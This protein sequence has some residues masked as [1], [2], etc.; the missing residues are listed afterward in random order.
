MW[1]NNYE[2]ECLP[3]CDSIGHD[4]DTMIRCFGCKTWYHPECLVSYYETP[5]DL[6]FSKV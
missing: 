5:E 1:A 2:F 3:G 4:K 6:D